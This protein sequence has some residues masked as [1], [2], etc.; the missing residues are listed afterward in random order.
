MR[1]LLSWEGHTHPT[2]FSSYILSAT[3]VNINGRDKAFPDT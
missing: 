1:V 3:S 2:S